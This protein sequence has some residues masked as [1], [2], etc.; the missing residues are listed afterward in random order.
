LSQKVFFIVIIYL[1]IYL[2]LKISEC[3]ISE[4]HL[5]HPTCCPYISY[6]FLGNSCVFISI[7]QNV[8]ILVTGIVFDH[9]IF[10]HNKCFTVRG[11]Q[12]HTHTGI[13]SVGFYTDGCA[14]N[15]EPSPCLEVMCTLPY[16]KH[17][18]TVVML[19]NLA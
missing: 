19:G 11:Q 8:C 9:L 16:H 5:C 18:P 7:L 4:C 17:N 12:P 14:I 13:S 15:L 1:F 3:L 10:G 6:I 2:V